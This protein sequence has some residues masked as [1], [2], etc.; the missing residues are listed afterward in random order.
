[1]DFEFTEEQKM[2]QNAV[3][4]FAQKN[5]TAE[6]AREYEEKREF[7]WDIYRKACELGFLG[8]H[9]PEEYGGQGYGI[10]EH[11]IFCYEVTK[12]DPPLGNAIRAAHFGAELILHFGTDEQK[13]KWLPKLAKGEITS[14]SMYTEPAGGSDITRVLDTRATKVS[15]NEWVIN[16]T[17]T[18]ITN[19]TIFAVGTV[20]TQTD[21][22]ANPPYRGQ[23]I[24]IVEKNE[25]VDVRPLK[26]KMGYHLSPL[27]EVSFDDLHVTDSD[28]LGGPANLNKG[29][30]MAIKFLNMTRARVGCHGVATAEAALEK[31]IKYANAREAFGRKISG[32]Q[33]LTHRIVDMATRIELA[34]SLLWRTAWVIEKSMKDSSYM[35]ES[36]KLASMLKWYGGRLAFEA[37]DLAIDVHGGH[38]YLGDYDVERWARY[39]KQLELIEGTKEIQKNTIARY[40]L[41]KEAVKHF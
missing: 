38:G 29:F 34:K 27:G 35:E 13:S 7:P 39:A 36:I 9:F 31:M 2:I 23:T 30:Y 17:K 12:A 20:L 33:G 21:I 28:I 37:C 6:K 11:F 22:N 5:L 32:F 1:M 3:R 14:S 18:L 41:G 24:F 10:I 26:D 8:L 15:D 25:N 40:I 16:G 19:A 4:E